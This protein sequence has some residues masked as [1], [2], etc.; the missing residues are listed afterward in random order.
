MDI[1]M[2][3][4][5]IIHL[6]KKA[7]F[8]QKDLLQKTNYIFGLSWPTYSKVALR[9][10]V[11]FIFEEISEYRS[12]L[13]FNPGTRLYIYAP[14]VTAV[15]PSVHTYVALLVGRSNILQ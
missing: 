11:Q 3:N 9:I 4:V 14:K 1:S 12:M 13:I 6:K 15:P 5:K 8:S 10:M 7:K 2:S